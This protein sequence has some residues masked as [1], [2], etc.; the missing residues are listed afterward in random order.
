M[1]WEYKTITI[2][3][4]MRFGDRQFAGKVAEEECNRL[5]EQGWELVVGESYQFD[6]NNPRLLLIFKRAKK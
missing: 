2:D 6:G 5:G 1:Q 3:R 4:M